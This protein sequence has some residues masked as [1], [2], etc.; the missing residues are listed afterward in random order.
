MARLPLQNVTLINAAVS[1]RTNL[2]RMAVPKFRNGLADH[3]EAHITETAPLSVVA[4]AIDTLELPQ[5][6]ALIKIDVEGHE[7]AALTG[8]QALIRRDRPVLIV[9]ANG[10]ADALLLAEGYH[11][12]VLP[13][14][15]NRVYEPAQPSH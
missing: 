4:L 14:S 8:M 15:S 9:E 12:R 11:V 3:Y 13:G 2:V 5:R 6:V 1:S 10:R 7:D